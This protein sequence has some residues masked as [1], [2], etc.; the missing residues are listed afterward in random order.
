MNKNMIYILLMF[1]LINSV[2]ALDYKIIEEKHSIIDHYII[3][4]LENN[5]LLKTEFEPELFLESPNNLNNLQIE[6]I[7]TKQKTKDVY[8]NDPIC[9]DV[10][11][12]NGSITQSCEDNFVF[13]HQEIKYYKEKLKITEYTKIQPNG[14]SIKP[15]SKLKINKGEKEIIKFFWKSNL[16]SQ[17]LWSINPNGTWNESW[18]YSMPINLNYATN[19]TL[20]NFTAKIVIDTKE[21]VDQGKLQSDCDD[22]RFVNS[23]NDTEI[24]H[25]IH[26]PFDSFNSSFGC[27]QNQTTY[28]VLIPELTQGSIL[29]LWLYYGNPTATSGRSEISEVWDSD[30]IRVYT[31]S[32]GNE[33]VLYDV[34]GQYNGTISTSPNVPWNNSIMENKTTLSLD[35]ELKTNTHQ[36][37]LDD[38]ADTW[39]N[40]DWTID[41]W[42]FIHNDPTATQNTFYMVREGSESQNFEAQP[43]FTTYVSSINDGVKAINLNS[44]TGS[45][46]NIT[47]LQWLHFGVSFDSTDTGRMYV[48]G[49]IADS[50]TNSGLNLDFST[51]DLIIGRR[52][53]STSQVMA[54]QMAF[55]RISDIGRSQEWFLANRNW[56]NYEFGEEINHS[57]EAEPPEINVTPEITGN[58]SCEFNTEPYIKLLNKI[59]WLCTINTNTTNTTDYKCYSKID[60]GG[61]TI[62][63]NPKPS[64]I[65]Q[66]G[67]IDYFAPQP[68]DSQIQLVKAYFRVEDLKPDIAVNFSVI[69]AGEHEILEFKQE[70]TPTYKNQEDIISRGIWIKENVSFFIVGMLIILVI[71]I[72]FVFVWRYANE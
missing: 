7:E 54:G 4:E 39:E 22:I 71:L 26:F 15:L 46:V 59:D 45:G 5:E 64:E 32:K 69:C 3:F 19:L 33:S 30:T 50:G 12:P 9:E 18:D 49:T 63:I 29:T 14:K 55:F 2:L 28:F 66:V 70:V 23:Q 52:E 47:F 37:D 10:T 8:L 56:D 11:N 42:Q 27:N 68:P 6:K 17:G 21:L 40:D 53:G 38:R 62:Q 57:V 16:N 65:Q 72:A 25:S 13:S 31:F 61:D 67:L 58:I 34:F 20:Y 35:F 44:F 48:N 24:L 60:I 1:I 43:D 51:T 41:F 36:V